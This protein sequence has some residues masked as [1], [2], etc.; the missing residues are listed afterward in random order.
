MV[1]GDDEPSWMRD[2]YA[3]PK[4]TPG[5]GV[6][7]AS[8]LQPNVPQSLYV[9]AETN[10]LLGMCVVPEVVVPPVHLAT[11]KLKQGEVTDLGRVSFPP[12]VQ[13]VVKVVDRADH[14]LSDVR[15]DC[16]YE[17]GYQW[18]V[19]R[20]TDAEGVVT[21]SVPAHSTGRFR[22]A[23]YDKQTETPTE[24]SIPYEVGGDESAGKEF[25]LRLSD[26][27]VEQMRKNTAAP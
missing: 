2:F 8:E 14:P 4:N 27:F 25:I 9:P 13:V 19:W 23:H 17:N 24:E 5:A 21:L 15:I 3:I 18:L 20:P 11:V 16:M 7:Y 26:A 12:G 22:T 10:L 6:S 1:P